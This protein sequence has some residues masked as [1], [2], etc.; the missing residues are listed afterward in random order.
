M[1]VKHKI[2]SEKDY[3]ITMQE[4]DSLMKKGENNLTALEI[5]SL[6][7]M[8]VAAEEFEDK[9][10]P[11]PMPK[12]IAGMVELKMYELKINQATL[13]DMLGVGKP[14]LSQILTGKRAPDVPFLKAVYSKLNIDPAFLLEHA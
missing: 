2:V 8:A 3:N 14:K 1:P 11:L 4:I 6:R 12:T 13:A 10:Y 9:Y 7:A 5:K